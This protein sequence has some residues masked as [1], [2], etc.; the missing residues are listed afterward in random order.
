MTHGREHAALARFFI[1]RRQ[2]LRIGGLGFLGLNL[3][4][5]L[6]AEATAAAN[7]PASMGALPR[8]KSCILLYYYGGPS[9]LDTWDMKPG[10]PAEIRGQFQSIGTKIPGIRVC[11]HLPRCAQLM[12]KLAL[13]RSM[14]HPMRNHNSAAVE[15]LC[16]RTPLKGDLELLAD[17]GNSFPC[18]GAA[19]NFLSR[20]HP[21]VPAH[22]ALPHVMHNVVTL[23]GQTGGFLG[24]AYNPF[25]V[26]RDPNDP[27]FRVGELEVQAD[28][29]LPRLE[30]RQQLLAQI[31]GRA[32]RAERVAGRRAMTVYQEKAFELLRSPAVR[33]AFDL[34]QEAPS[35][36]DRY[37]RNKLGQSLILA[38]RL[39]EAGV[40]FVN[41]NDK[42]YNGQLENWDSHE[43]N[44]SRLKNDL[45]PPADLGFSALIEDLDARGLL[46]ST[47]VVALA[48]F[49]RTPRINKSAGRDHWPDCFTVVLAGGGVHGGA[50][51]GASDKIGAFPA[52]DLVTP[53][54]LAATLFWRF[55][56]EP[57]TEIRDLT[58]RPYRLA[59]GAPIHKLFS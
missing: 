21:E 22:V 28:L 31:D 1:D 47:L 7:K 42:V 10:A 19:L 53:G 57:S 15:A 36:R 33:R 48:E 50:V 6:E 20:G 16:G 18:Y 23:P 27:D 17:D 35:M 8:L 49:G 38:R 55:G 46:D 58:S 24:A 51:Y 3:A 59:D 44:F 52:A 39:V 29:S 54:D 37:G 56:L 40:R 32:I 2:L 14:H 43:N 5:V 30:N 41:V 13:I 45:L 9:H 11:E 4:R 34:S 12:G 25:Q 26:N